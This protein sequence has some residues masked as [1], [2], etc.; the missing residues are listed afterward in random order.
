MSL[1]EKGSRQRVALRRLD[2]YVAIRLAQ[3][4]IEPNVN[5]IGSL[6]EVAV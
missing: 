1:R 6:Y 5:I 4:G 3:H 2:L